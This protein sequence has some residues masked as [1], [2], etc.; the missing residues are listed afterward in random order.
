MVWIGRPA[1]WGLAYNGEGGVRDA[2]KIL[3]DEFQACMA[4]S[5]C[6]SLQDL[7]PELLVA[8]E[9]SSRL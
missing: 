2:L 6:T 4:L 5:G 9:H 7:R 8:V 3:E 1:L